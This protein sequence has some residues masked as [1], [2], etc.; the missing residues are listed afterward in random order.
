MTQLRDLT[1]LILLAAIEPDEE[2]RQVTL[3]E[4]LR[5]VW[6]LGKGEGSGPYQLVNM[7]EANGVELSAGEL[8]RLRRGLEVIQ[9]YELLE[10]LRGI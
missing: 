1:T 8:V 6:L 5:R 3:A 4:I 7:A 9:D 2:F 10:K